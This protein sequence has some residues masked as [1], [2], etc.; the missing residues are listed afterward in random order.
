MAVLLFA[1]LIAATDYGN[2]KANDQH[3]FAECREDFHRSF[4]DNLE[5]RTSYPGGWVKSIP[6]GGIDRTI[7]SHR[8]LLQ[9]KHPTVEPVNQLD[10]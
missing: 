10:P 9:T 7:T 6:Y 8:P 1:G 5:G 4:S 2:K 3:G